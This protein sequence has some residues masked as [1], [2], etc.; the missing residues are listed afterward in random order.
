MLGTLGLVA[1]IRAKLARVFGIGRSSSYYQV[2]QPARDEELRQNITN[3]LLANPAYGHK[4]VALELNC[5]KNQIR[6]VMKLFGLEPTVHRRYRWQPVPIETQIVLR[7]NRITDLTPS[8]LHHV[9]ASDFTYLWCNSR[10]YYLATVLDLFTRQ[11]VGWSIGRRHT[12]QL[13]HL[14]VCDALS[15]HQPPACFHTDQGSEYTAVATVMLV[16]AAGSLFSWSAK[17]SPWQNGYQESL[18]QNFK[19]ELGDLSRFKT[20]GELF[21]A[22]AKQIY[23]YNHH[24]IHTALLMSPVQFSKQSAR[25]G[26]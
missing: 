22:V 23:Y 10:W 5:G 8:Y 2:T 20:E 6:R 13:I 15:S 21:E 24:R 4:R 1:G 3:V 26:V 14:A 12:A 18:Y 19:L 9:R 25:Q 11:L 16:E 7:P 17:G